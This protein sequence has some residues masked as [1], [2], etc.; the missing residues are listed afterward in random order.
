MKLLN[1]SS[2]KFLGKFFRKTIK[3]RQ[4]FNKKNVKFQHISIIKLQLFHLIHDKCIR[5]LKV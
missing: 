5:R 2:F 1:Q 3:T 4:D